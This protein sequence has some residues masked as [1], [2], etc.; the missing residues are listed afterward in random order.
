MERLAANPIITP[1]SVPPSRQDVEVYCTINPAAVWFA[2]QA[3]LLLRVGERPRAVPGTVGALI[4]DHRDGRTLVRRFDLSD[5]KL[6]TLDGRTFHYHGKRLLTSLSHLR[7]ARSAD[8]RTWRIDPAPAI[9]PTT[10]WEA[11]GCEDA[12]ITPL[13]GLYRI[14]YTAV[15]HLGVCVML[16]ETQDFVTFEKRGVIFPTYNKDVCIFPE[17]VGGRYVCRHRPFRSEFNEPCIWTAWSPD[18]LHWGDHSVLHR[19]APLTWESERVGA[20]APPLRTAAGW[21][22]IYHACDDA[23]RYRLGAMLS[24]LERPDRLLA[25]G[26]PVLEP[27]EPYETGGIYGQCVFSNGLLAC[28]DGRLTVFYG[29]ADTVTAAATTSVDEMLEAVRQG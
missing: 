23:G 20:G 7:I 1:A 27:R 16:A 4:Y 14:T 26:G 25:R 6:Q 12:R 24:E 2:G 29:A 3:L 5:P 15:G 19:P 10:E 18:L 11:Y 13:E 21:L 17:R 28:D 9:F 8:L 22:E